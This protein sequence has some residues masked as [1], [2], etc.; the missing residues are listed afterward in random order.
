MNNPVVSIIMP[1]KNAAAFL[2]ESIESIINQ[3]FK[4]WELIVIDD[5]ST[6]NTWDILSQ[7]KE[8]ENRINALQNSGNGIIQALQLGHSKSSGN[9]IT[10][11]DADDIMPYDKINTLVNLL[12]ENGTGNVATGKVEYFSDKELG[13]GY[14]KYQ[15]WLN[16]LTQNQS[17][18]LE[19]YKECPIASPC[20]MVWSEDFEACGGFDHDV[21]PED[22]DLV[23]RFYKNKLN[24]V[25]V[26]EVLHLWR[27]SP[28]RASRTDENY[29]DN[30]FL[31][32]KINQFLDIDYK[33]EKQ[34]TLWGAG[35]K[36][37]LLAQKLQKREIPFSW[38]CNTP[39]KIG[40]DIYGKTLEN[41]STFVLT[42]SQVII[43]VANEEEQ[44]SIQSKLEKEEAHNY[45]YFC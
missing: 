41:S 24:V 7:Y 39:T 29:K 21:Y 43:A 27:D 9:M 8:T 42:D 40:K 12:I 25:S 16:K 20:W 1:A 38:I 36:G 6:D 35:K 10:R 4:N 3:S 17:N 5:N 30:R 11:M 45:F 15:N 13:N 2:K 18:Y 31:D 26:D 14:I 44:I 23:F 22:Y 33:E 34:L 37:K 19:I 32:L 28:D